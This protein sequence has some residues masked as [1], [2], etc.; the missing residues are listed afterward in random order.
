MTGL[1]ISCP[2]CKRPMGLDDAEVASVHPL[3]VGEVECPSCG[4]CFRA[5]RGVVVRREEEE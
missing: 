5:E 2:E 4:L 1:V 3:T